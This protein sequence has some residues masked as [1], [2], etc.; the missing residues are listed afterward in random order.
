MLKIAKESFSDWKYFILLSESHFPLISVEDMEI[1]YESAYSQKFS[2]LQG[3]LGSQD[4]HSYRWN[5]CYLDSG[6]FGKSIEKLIVNQD[7]N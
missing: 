3:W 5:K 7:S 2:Y 6:T 1:G 4:V